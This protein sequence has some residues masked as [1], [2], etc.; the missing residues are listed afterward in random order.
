MI[1][2]VIENRRVRFD[3]DQAAAMKAGLRISSRLLN[4]VRPVQK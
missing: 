1:A 2:F 3:V 4:V